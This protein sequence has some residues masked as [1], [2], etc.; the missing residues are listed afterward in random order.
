MVGGWWNNGGGNAGGKHGGG[1]GGGVGNVYSCRWYGS[2]GGYGGGCCDAGAVVTAWTPLFLVSR[3]CRWRC[4]RRSRCCG[5]DPG[6]WDA[7][8]SETRS[9][10]GGTTGT[11]TELLLLLLCLYASVG[12]DTW[13]IGGVVLLTA[14]RFCETFPTGEGP[15]SPPYGRRLRVTPLGTAS[16]LIIVE[17]VIVGLLLLALLPA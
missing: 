1:G 6:P 12:S 10:G 3:G 8:G 15:V 13:G 17:V 5:R 14:D 7:L 16:A 9:G 11:A 4:C 2:F